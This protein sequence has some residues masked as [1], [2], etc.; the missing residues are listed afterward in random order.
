M[1]PSTLPYSLGPFHVEDQVVVAETRHPGDGTGRILAAVEADEGKTLGEKKMRERG[2]EEER[3]VRRKNWGWCPP[4]IPPDPTLD[5]P[6][7]LSLAR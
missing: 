5:C 6:V 1:P 3:G 7:A 2:E 4:K